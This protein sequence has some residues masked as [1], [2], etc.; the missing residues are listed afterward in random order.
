MNK[1]PSQTREAN[2]S[3]QKKFLSNKKRLHMNLT[4]EVFELFKEYAK[5]NDFTLAEALK[6]LL[7]TANLT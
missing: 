4:P 1:Y 3:R 7:E 2:R 5:K 6:K